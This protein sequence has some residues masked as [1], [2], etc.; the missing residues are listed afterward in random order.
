MMTFGTE[1][2]QAALATWLEGRK[3]LAEK[4]A[5]D[6][7]MQM[8]PVALAPG[9]EI[10][11]TPGAHSELIRGIITS[12]AP[13]L[14]PGAEVIYVGD[15][16]DKAGH[17]EEERLATLGVTVDR[18]GKMPDV[19]LYFSEKDWLLL[20]EG[21]TSHGPVDPKRHNELADLFAGAQPGLIYSHGLSGP[22]RDGPLSERYLLGDRGVVRRRTEPSHSLRRRA[23]SRTL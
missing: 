2:W 13:R 9:R 21:V 16:G 12:F 7:E 18:H 22:G 15:T 3:T 23:V 14:A 4:W 8:I 11:L 5:R 1:A 19:V 20:V 6:R 17:F 10:A